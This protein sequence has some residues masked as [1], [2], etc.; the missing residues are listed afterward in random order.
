MNPA[1]PNKQV[2]LFLQGPT[3]TFYSQIAT[4][5]LR[6]GRP[7]IRINLCG[8]DM[9]AWRHRGAV[10]LGALISSKVNQWTLLVG[11][12]PIAYAISLGRP[13]GLPLDDRQTQELLLTSAQS[14]LAA[15]LVSNFG[16]SRL[17]ATILAVLFGVQLL[18]PSAEVRIAFSVLYL[19][20]FG[21][22]LIGAPDRR[23]AFFT[24][25]RP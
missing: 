23:K 3:S 16:F 6:A 22:L 25:L 18:F 7:V 10:G 5:L 13:E 9:F 12:L 19:A 14:L 15:L 17:E 4:H 24:V 11:A 1:A 21:V 2:F 20:I 8:S